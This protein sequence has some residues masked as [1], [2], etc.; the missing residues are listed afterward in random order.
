MISEKDISNP[1]THFTGLNCPTSV[2]TT[3]L[4]CWP[5]GTRRSPAG[6]RELKLAVVLLVKLVL[7]ETDM[8]IVYCIS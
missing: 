3:P 6:S 4:A 1:G 8:Y 7:N 5:P 2:R